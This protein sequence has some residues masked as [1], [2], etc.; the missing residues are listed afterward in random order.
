[1]DVVEE[2]RREQAGRSLARMAL[3]RLELAGIALSTGM[4]GRDMTCMGFDAGGAALP[5]FMNCR[6]EDWVRLEFKLGWSCTGIRFERAFVI[7]YFRDAGK[8]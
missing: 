7:R 8:V 3:S 5:S 4:R 1:M 6:E 2:V